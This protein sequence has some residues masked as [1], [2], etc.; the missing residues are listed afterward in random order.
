MQDEELEKLVDRAEQAVYEVREAIDNFNDHCLDLK[1][2]FSD[3]LADSINQLIKSG[4]V[5]GAEF[6]F[7]AGEQ[8]VVFVGYTHGGRLVFREQG[9]ED[10]IRV[11]GDAVLK[12]LDKF[13]RRQ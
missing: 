9:Q 7:K 2:A 1:F 5:P 6:D 3:C 13:N 4:F 12:N 8:L 11:N 10:E